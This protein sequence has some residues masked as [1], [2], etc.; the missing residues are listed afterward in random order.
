MIVIETRGARLPALGFGT[1][2]LR[3]AACREMLPVAVE[4]G[5]R[6]IDTARAYDNEAEVGQGLQD[7]GLPRGELWVTT[8][9]WMDELA[10][11]GIAARLAESLERLRLDYVDLLLIHWP[12]EPAA[13]AEALAAMEEQ[14]RAGR[15][16]H[17]G[18]S[19]FTVEQ[20][21]AACDAGFEL[22][23]NQVEY[24]P[25]LSQDDL[26]GALDER[27]MVLTAYAP[28]A[29]GR[30]FEEPTIRRIAER[31]GKSPA[32]VALR[33]LVQ[34]RNVAAIPK[35]GSRKHAESNMAIFDFALEETEMAEI[36][37]LGRERRRIVDPAWAPDWDAA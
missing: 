10:P 23:T 16:R 20:L 24:H 12:V 26:R 8:K 18:V 28:L 25:F 22:L 27:D 21:T 29:R 15:V 17:L 34:Q 33:W 2:E 36:A 4:L 31:H 14:R 37:G 6:H 30:V 13:H 11:E 7:A 19:N 5:Y 9:L 32:Q 3:G 1:W 35:A